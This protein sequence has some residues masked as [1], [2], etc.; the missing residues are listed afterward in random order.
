V[1]REKNLSLN[2]T[3]P[4][5]KMIKMLD[6]KKMNYQSE[7]DRDQKTKLRHE[8]EEAL[9]E[10]FDEIVKNQKDD[11]L[12]AIRAIK[13]KY[14][15]IKDREKRELAIEVEK[16]K[17]NQKSGFD[18]VKIENEIRQFTNKSRVKSFFPWE[19]YFAEVF[20]EKNGF[21][22][23][24]GNPPYIKEYTNRNAFDGVRDSPY[25]Q[26]KMDIW[27]MFA[28]QGLDLLRSKTGILC[29]IATNNWVTNTGAS[30]LRN[31]ISNDATLITLLD[32]GDYKIFEK[33][34]IQ[35]MVLIAQ[36]SRENESYQF[37]LRK[38]IGN[39]CSFANVM[40]LLK[41]IESHNCEYLHSRF[42]RKNMIDKF[43]VFSNQIEENLLRKIF[44]KSN[45][46]LSKREVG[47]GIDVHQD[48]VNQSSK[49]ILGKNY[50]VGDGIFILSNHEKKK[51][52]LKKNELKIIK[53]YYT[54]NEMQ[55]YFGN[56]LNSNWIIYT[57]SSFK[58]TDKI[59]SFP[60]IKKHL[61]RYSKIITSDNKP[62]GLHRSRNENLFIGEKIISL[63]KCL[64]PTFTYTDFDCYVSQSFF[65]IKTI[66]VNLRFLTGLLNS[67]LVAFWLRKKGKMQGLNYQIDKEPLLSIPIFVPQEEIQN[68]IIK[69]V[70]NIIEIKRNDIHAD[71][72]L[73]SKKIDHIIYSFYELNEDDI[74]IIESQFNNK[75]FQI[76]EAEV[77]KAELDGINKSKSINYELYSCPICRAYVMSFDLQHHEREKHG[78]RAL[79]WKKIG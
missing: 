22:I 27:Y 56:A 48:F 21:D 18:L 74:F 78:G 46:F 57:D 39:D 16:Q 19:L 75:D 23:V 60:N 45:F 10:I 63:R 49:E 28:C 26:G 62:Y 12:N 11:F 53:P 54:T 24:I 41:K 36:K 64:E 1:E 61:D 8:I 52:N 4:T 73:I 7:S 43:F 33:A 34:G 65:V 67:K 29:F 42:S 47:T 30:K 58:D 77:D 66:N 9:I 68:R 6:Q 59:V 13:R 51:L 2:F 25:Y 35:T 70:D 40:E 76:D 15:V 5:T 69:L 3:D 31:K 55:K 50:N 17:L 37:D 14:S 44:N 72:S 38:L 20:M 32:F 79:V 71:T